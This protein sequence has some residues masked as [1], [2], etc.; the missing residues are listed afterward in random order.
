MKRLLI[1]LFLGVCFGACGHRSQPVAVSQPAVFLPMLP[2]VQLEGDEVVDYMQMHYWDRFDFADTLFL[3][4]VDTTQMLEAYAAYVA[5]YLDAR[6]TSTL[7]SLMRKASVSRPMLEYFWMLGEKVLDDPNSPLRSSEL[8]S[9]VLRA[10]LQSSFFD[11]WERIA[12]EHDLHM[13]LQNRVGQPSNN[14]TYTLASGGRGT[15]HG[16]KSDYVLLFISNPDCPMCAQLQ[17]EISES[18]L[19]SELIERGDLKVVMIYTD[20]D[21]TVWRNH[22]TDVPASWINGYDRDGVIGENALYDL[23]AIP[24]IYLLDRAKRVLVKDSASIPD[25]EKML[26]ARL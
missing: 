16:V 7:D 20:E 11:P 5:H 9:A 21:L 24:S 8:Y 10:V 25:V 15:L 14:F 2:P 13:A 3:K 6:E 23:R 18:P 4:R 1:F 22:A 26:D 12:P 19:L 17:R